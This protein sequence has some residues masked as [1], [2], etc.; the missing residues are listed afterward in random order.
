MCVCVRMLDH[1]CKRVCVCVCRVIVY[2]HVPVSMLALENSIT[3]H[4]KKIKLKKRGVPAS[5]NQM[6]TAKP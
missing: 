5:T 1:I 2:L 3:I 4:F 6:F